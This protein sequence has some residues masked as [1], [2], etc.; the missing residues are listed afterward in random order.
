[1]D[2]TCALTTKLLRYTKNRLFG[3]NQ[4][5]IKAAALLSGIKI[6]HKI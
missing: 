3:V 1:M 2:D 6:L 4:L 5:E